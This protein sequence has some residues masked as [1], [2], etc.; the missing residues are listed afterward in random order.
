MAKRRHILRNLAILF[1]SIGLLSSCGETDKGTALKGKVADA[2][3]LQ[4]FFD[5]I[6]LKK[7]QVIA[8]VPLA[9]DGSFRIDFQNPL[10]P[11]IY[12]IRVGTQQAFFFLD[13]REKTMEINTSLNQIGTYDF[14]IE[15]ADE[16]TEMIANLR[17]IRNRE[18]SSDEAV[19]LIK[20]SDPI[21]G[22]HYL[23]TTGLNPSMENIGTMKGVASGLKEKYPDSEYTAMFASEV[24][25]IEK[26]LARQQAMEKIKVGEKAPDIALPNPNGEVM[27]L[28]DLRGQ[29]VLL[30]FWA[31]WCGPCRRANP[32][33]VKSYN[34]YKD[35]GFAVFSV[36]LDRPGQAER[37]KQ[38]IKQD[39]L[40]WP[41]H[42]SDLKYWNSEP[43][44]VYG[45]RGIP[46][47]FLIDKDGTI[48]ST[49]VSPYS[50]DNELEKLL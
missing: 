26:Q 2:Q 49:S 41:Y 47:T 15:G 40:N 44:A 9:G 16:G 35:K 38:A 20:E 3:D 46:K 50:L 36:S 8:K 48:A 34:K 17:K 43:A 27:K 25:N 11:G 18:I 29:V 31:S 12:R 1:M 4:L 6:T 30:D 45:V 32:H 33:V 37:W 28:S 10:K 21:A 13:G 24:T 14:E 39:K 42:V 19:K 7:T 23:L 22:M 5:A